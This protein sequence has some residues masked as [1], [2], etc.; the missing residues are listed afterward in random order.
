MKRLILSICLSALLPMTLAAFEYVD[1]LTFYTIR[2]IDQPMLDIYGDTVSPGISYFAAEAGKADAMVHVGYIE[3][4]VVAMYLSAQDTTVLLK[5]ERFLSTNNGQLYRAGTHEYYRNGRC[6]H[7]ETYRKG[8]LS[9]YIWYDDNGF[10]TRRYKTAAKQKKPGFEIVFYGNDDTQTVQQRIDMYPQTNR[11]RKIETYSN[12]GVETNYYD[13][14]GVK[15]PFTLPD[16]AGGEE[17]LS[18][19][20]SKEFVLPEKYIMSSFSYRLKGAVLADGTFRPQ[21]IRQTSSVSSRGQ[22]G[23][24]ADELIELVY[25]QLQKFIAQSC[26][27]G[28]VNGKKE[29]MV[30]QA[31]IRY[32]PIFFATDGDTL[33]CDKDDPFVQPMSKLGADVYTAVNYST[34]FRNNPNAPYF[35]LPSH[36]GDTLVLRYFGVS[37]RKPVLVERYAAYKPDSILKTGQNEIILNYGTRLYCHYE[38]D[39]LQRAQERDSTG[40]LHAEYTFH[41]K[42]KWVDY[43]KP[44]TKTT[45]DSEGNILMRI[46]FAEFRD[47]K[48]IC[49]DASGREIKYDPAKD[50]PKGLYPVPQQNKLSQKGQNDGT[51]YLVVEKMPEFPGGQKALYQFLSENVKYPVIARENRIQG[52]VRCQFVVNKDGSITDVEVVKSGGDASLDKE[53][54]RV[55]KAMPNWIPGKQQ[56]KLVRVKYTVPV[57]FKL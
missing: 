16:L 22:G 35:A 38:A 29:Q 5:T 31:D 13:M 43:F 26:I 1:S 2:D 28:E 46:E 24:P 56:G 36:N 25:T 6:Y 41:P 32:S 8:N 23:G 57:T 37:D 7:A 33:F 27:P 9:A 54:I 40:L 19:R 11:V 30:V 45:Y 55:L 51:V 47:D 44:K 20:L 34:Y 18:K 53:A 4:T 15:L 21:S 14:Q 48:D 50:S 12:Q 42:T 39:M 52:Q 49:Y 10:I 3:D 17:Q